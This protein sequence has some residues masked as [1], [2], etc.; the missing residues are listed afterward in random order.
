MSSPADTTAFSEMKRVLSVQKTAFINEGEVTAEVRIERLQRAYNMI[1]ENQHDIIDVSTSDFGNRSR[2]QAQMSEVLSVMGGFEHSMKNLRHWM[3][4]ERRKVMFPLNLMGAKARVEY[5][6]KGVVGV[7]GTWNFPVYTALSPVAGILAAGNRAMVKLSELNPQTAAL[8]KALIDRYFDESELYAV[9]GGP[10][11]GAEFAALPL[12]HIIF[13]GGTN[14]GKHILHAA[15]NNLTPCTLELGGK[16]PVIVGR[17]YELK[18]AAERIMTGKALNIGQACLAPDYCFVPEEKLEDFTQAAISH[19][20]EMFPSVLEN[21]DYTAVINERHHQ[22]LASMIEDA[23][24]KGGDVRV[25]NPANEDF[26]QQKPG[27]HKMPMTLVI[28]P[29][30]DMRVMQEELFGAILCIKSYKNVGECIQYI[31]SRPRP[32]GLYYFGED[33]VEE[34]MVLDRTIS[35]GVSINDVMAHAS[36]EDLPFGGIGHS[37]MGN[38]HGFDGFKTFSHQRAIYKQMKLDLMKLSGMMPPYGEKCQKQLD[39]LTKAKK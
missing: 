2:H 29:S 16:S 23:R 30:D 1:A 33:P 39:K 20:S 37:G 22:R 28:N 3:K 14:I 27:I 35:G 31:N 24:S 6:P 13:T 5:V 34:R 10:E 18:K 15:M 11:T 4:N 8:M 26:S 9:T 21:P 19:F 38:Y 17:S 25:I 36:C 32:L 12:D 7:L